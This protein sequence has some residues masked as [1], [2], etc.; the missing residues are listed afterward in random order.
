VQIASRFQAEN[1]AIRDNSAGESAGED[2]GTKDASL[3]A[4]GLEVPGNRLRKREEQPMKT[5]MVIGLILIVLG[6]VALGY[7]G[8]A[9]ITTRDTIARVGPVEVQADREHPIPLAPILSG[10][11]LVA[12]IGLLL[13]GAGKKEA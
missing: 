11:A 8:V 5:T 13:V 10:V 4:N 7:Q 1:C 9:W 12:G 2:A 6:V 3:L